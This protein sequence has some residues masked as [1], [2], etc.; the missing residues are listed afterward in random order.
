[1]ESQG[2]ISDVSG[3]DEG[4]GE[5]TAVGGGVITYKYQY[6]KRWNWDNMF[7]YETDELR[8]YFCNQD[9]SNIFCTKE[10]Q[11]FQIPE[12]EMMLIGSKK[13]VR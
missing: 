12:Q 1:M 2:P 6:P 9:F 10:M 7:E 5:C 13:K 3:G 4:E 8:D 11:E